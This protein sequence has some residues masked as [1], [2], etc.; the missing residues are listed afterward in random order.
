[1]WNLC[2]QILTPVQKMRSILKANCADR[3][4]C[5]GPNVAHWTPITPGQRLDQSR[6]ADGSC[7]GS[8][9]FF[10]QLAGI[11]NILRSCGADRLM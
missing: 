5:L 7:A 10:F 1:M 8:R 6:G 3:T 2:T 9:G 4:G 11:G